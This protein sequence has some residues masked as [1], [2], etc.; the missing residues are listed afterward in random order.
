MSISERSFEALITGDPRMSYI[1][2]NRRPFSTMY[3]SE[4]TYWEHRAEEKARWPIDSRS[5]KRCVMLAQEDPSLQGENADLNRFL[6]LGV[7]SHIIHTE[8]GST[9]QSELRLQSSR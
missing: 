2:I 4:Q 1:A 3:A 8:D 7:A 5:L 9:E 6:C